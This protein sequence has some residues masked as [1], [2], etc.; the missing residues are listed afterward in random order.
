MEVYGS[1]GGGGGA[2]ASNLSVGS[3]E[4]YYIRK[5]DPYGGVGHERGVANIGPSGYGGGGGGGYSKGAMDSG[6]NGYQG[7]VY[8]RWTVQEVSA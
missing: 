3:S 4:V 5:G 1:A 7:V 8:L 2:G 6:S